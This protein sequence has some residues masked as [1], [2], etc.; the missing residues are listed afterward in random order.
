MCVFCIKPFL[1]PVDIHDTPAMLH[2]NAIRRVGN[3]AVPFPRTGLDTTGTACI[4]QQS[5]SI[6]CM[7]SSLWT[8]LSTR[9]HQAQTSVRED[10]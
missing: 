5:E 8:V 4:P 7:C 3:D 1:L 2:C 10:P 9:R 6:M